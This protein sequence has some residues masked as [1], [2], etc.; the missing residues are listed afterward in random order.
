MR[1]SLFRWVAGI[2]SVLLLAA[3]ALLPPPTVEDGATEEA[4]LP[5][6]D[7]EEGIPFVQEDQVTCYWGMSQ[8]ILSLPKAIDALNVEVAV[9][10]QKQGA[11]IGIAEAS[12]AEK[13]EL[14]ETYY[15]CGK[16][17]INLVAGGEASGN[18]FVWKAT[19]GEYRFV[20]GGDDSQTLQQFEVEW[21][22]QA[23][24]EVSATLYI[25]FA[26]LLGGYAALGSSGI[27][28]TLARFQR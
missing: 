4:M 26:V 18:E 6:C 10:W 16:Q 23:T 25:L 19:S 22:Y 13:C 15:E 3:P 14:K 17:S 5:P 7:V 28:K 27:K 12:E 2:A 21:S 9:A 20:A 24:L 1:E 8:D 11:W